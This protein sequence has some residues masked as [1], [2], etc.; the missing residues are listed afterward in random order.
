MLK[1][2][3]MSG[4]NE[5]YGF[6]IGHI[7]IIIPAFLL[8]GA[9][10]SLVNKFKILKYC[11]P[12]ANKAVAYTL[13]SCVGVCLSVCACGIIP[14]FGSLY[15]SGAGIGP[16][17]TFL[18]SGP[19]INITAIVLTFMMMGTKMGIARMLLTFFGAYLIGII[20]SLVFKGNIGD[21]KKEKK[22]IKDN[23]RKGWQ[24]STLFFFLITFTFLPA[25]DKIPYKLKWTLYGINFLIICFVAWKFLS[26]DEIISWLKK[27]R[28]FTAK[29]IVPMMIGVFMIGVLR[30]YF[31][32]SESDIIF[33]I[34][35]NT[36]RANFI[37]S[38]A[39]AII[40][41]GSC[42]SVPFVAALMAM[43]LHHGPA[44]ALLIAGPAVSFPTF[45]AIRNIMGFKRS[46]LYISLVVVFATI[47]GKLFGSMVVI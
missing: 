47:V 6:I 23:D 19:A 9:I 46:F 17:I 35:G 2:F 41:F 13:S 29:I 15:T 28:H 27:T 26:K 38:I 1:E 12:Q 39:A 33:F 3:L 37:A 22:P 44:M 45:L 32:N 20:F 10:G 24:T 40:Y 4:Y 5:V 11:G 7:F 8:S 25:F 42:V 14:L 21:Y 31:G 30:N 34:R 36:W 18:F 16:A 43:G